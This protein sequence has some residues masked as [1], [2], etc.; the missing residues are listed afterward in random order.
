MRYL[1]GRTFVV[2][3][4]HYALKY[5]LDQW[6]STI[7]QHQWVS[8]IFGFDFRVKYQPSRLNTVADALSCHDGDGLLL[9]AMST[10]VFSLYDELRHEFTTDDM[11]LARRDAV[12]VGDHGASWRVH[13]SLTTHHGCMFIPSSSA[14][15]P[16]VLQL[17]HTAGHEGI[18]KMLQRLRTNFYLEHDRRVINDFVWSCATCQRNKMEALHPAGLLQALLVSSCVWADIAM[19]FIEALPKV[20][21]KSVIL[22]VVDRFSK[23]A[24]FIPLGHPYTASSVARAFFHRLHDF[25]DS[26]VNDRDPMF[27]GHLWR[28]LFCRAGVQLRMSIAFH[29]QTDGPRYWLEW[30]P[31]VEYCYNTLFH[32][33]LRTTPFTVVYGRAPPAPRPVGVSD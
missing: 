16:D 19:D 23:Y 26:I 4:D 13:D 18:Q 21:G 30:L 6:L 12:L 2:R 22:T 15:L 1:W 31:W 33:A 5:M 17:V 25:P 29:P 24:H 14:V 3:T 11:L 7:P 27:T 28:D 9:V 10:P 8:K 32:S 20:H